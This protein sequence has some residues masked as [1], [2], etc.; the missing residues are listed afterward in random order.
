MRAFY[1]GG[2]RSG[3]SQLAAQRAREISKTDDVCC[4]VTALESDEEMKRRIA[5]HRSERSP[6]WRVVEE[7]VRLGAALRE[8]DGK[9]AVILIDCLTLW[10]ANCLWPDEA[11]WPGERAA[12]LSALR[13]CS[14]HVVIVSNEVGTGIVPANAASRLFVD[15]QG[16]LNQAVAAVCDEVIQAV[17]G[18]G[19][20]IK[21][22]R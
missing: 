7:P 20:P 5:A 15:E 22:A 9:H 1:V 4:I 14:S 18:I 17:V 16:W 8:V 6:S 13:E 3:K 10:T 11:V 2:A 12:F 21:P 19:V